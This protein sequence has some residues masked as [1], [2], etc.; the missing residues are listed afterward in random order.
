MIIYGDDGRPLNLQEYLYHGKKTNG[1]YDYYGYKQN[2]GIR[3]QIMKKHTST[4][5]DVSWAT[6]QGNFAAA[7]AAYGS[8]TYGV[9]PND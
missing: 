7:W 4:E 6:G 1:S 3:W 2:G 8:Q 9:A 5:S